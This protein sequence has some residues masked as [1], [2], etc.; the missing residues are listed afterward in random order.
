MV[1][2]LRTKVET[3]NVEKVLDGE[4]NDFIEAEIKLKYDS[5]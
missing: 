4:I 1:K 2:D 3:S 5:F